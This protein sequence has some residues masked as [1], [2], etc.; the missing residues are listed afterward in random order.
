MSGSGRAS[1]LGG[2][3][4][5]RFVPDGSGGGHGRHPAHVSIVRQWCSHFSSR[6]LGS[7]K[8]GLAVAVLGA[9][10]PLLVALAALSCRHNH[11]RTS[12]I[13]LYAGEARLPGRPRRVAWLPLF[14]T[15]GAASI[16]GSASGLAASSVSPP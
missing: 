13:R 4:L 1:A 9:L 15:S 8:V 11:L 16:V 10:P 7:G 12:A 2:R 6:A 14:R 5:R 3:E